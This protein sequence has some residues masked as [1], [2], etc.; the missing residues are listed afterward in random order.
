MGGVNQLGKNVLANMLALEASLMA[1]RSY[2]IC[3]YVEGVE[4]RDI[5]CEV[6]GVPL[7][8]YLKKELRYLKLCDTLIWSPLEPN[9]V[10]VRPSFLSADRSG[11]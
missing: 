6:F 11:R 10:R 4:W 3:K 9:L 7:G 5:N 1:L 8:S 2:S